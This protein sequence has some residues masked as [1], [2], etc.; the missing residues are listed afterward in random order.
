MNK[1][2]TVFSCLAFGV[3]TAASAAN[4]PVH[5]AKKAAPVVAPAATAGA[6]ATKSEGSAARRDASTG[7]SEAFGNPYETPLLLNAKPLMIGRP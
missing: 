5:P 6:K 3:A 7:A 1:C 4:V 2:A